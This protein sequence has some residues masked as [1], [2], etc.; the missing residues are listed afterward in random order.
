MKRADLAV[1]VS[2]LGLAAGFLLPAR[3]HCQERKDERAACSNNLKQLALACVQYCDDKRFFPH[4]GPINKLDN[5]GDTT[6]KGSDVAPRCLRSLIFLNYVDGPKLYVCQGSSDAAKEWKAGTPFGWL[7]AAPDDPKASPIAK[8]SKNDKDADALTDLSYGWTLRG[9]TSN[10][11][12]NS[13]TI[14][15]RASK[16]GKRSKQT[17]AGNHEGGWNVACVDGHV[18]FV[19]KGEKPALS[20]A[21]ANDAKSPALTVWDEANAGDEVKEEKK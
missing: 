2:I 15:D 12:S 8:A 11:A 18:D 14:A 20:K 7:G 17:L 1:V 19:K 3:A 5:N 16:L 21:D 9:Y 10:A 4:L 13:K 6:P